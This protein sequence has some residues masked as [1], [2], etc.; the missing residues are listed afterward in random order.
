MKIHLIAPH[1]RLNTGYGVQCALWSRLWSDAG[2]EVVIQAATGQRGFE[3][4]Y[5]GIRVLPCSARAGAYGMDLALWYSEQIRP[6]VT[7]VLGDAFPLL[8]YADVLRELPSLALWMPVDCMPLG[9]GDSAVLRESGATPVAMSRFGA[10]ELTLAGYR[11]LYVPH[12]IDMSLFRPPSREEY[13]KSR[14]A[15]G[16]SDTTFV[17]GINAS[18][19]DVLDRKN[20][21]IQL[22]AFS[23]FVRH[24]PDSL[25]LAHTCP[26]STAMDLPDLAHRFL[27]IPYGKIIWP[28]QN[29]VITGDITQAELIANIYWAAD[30]GS[31]CSAGEGFGLCLLESQACGVP[32]VTTA[33]SSMPEVAAPGAAGALM[34]TG[35][36]SWQPQHKA[37]W[38][39]PSIKAVQMAYTAAHREWQM[40]DSPFAWLSRKQVARAHCASYDAKFVMENHWVPALERLAGR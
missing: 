11:P 38:M 36:P 10:Q 5:R 32:I 21:L 26:V 30:F 35:P 19:G 39:R 33:F 16:I 18:N 29:R 4:Q 14:D 24:A 12:G 22:E 28:D 1:P 25:L 3:S 13:G 27:G 17:I 34:V 2:H 15:L 40:R 20:W 37:A 23:L 9:A 7:I 8:P 6:D 31:Y